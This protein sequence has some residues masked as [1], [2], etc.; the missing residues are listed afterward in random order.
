MKK[1]LQ[2]PVVL[3][4]IRILMATAFSVFAFQQVP[5]EHYSMCNVLFTCA[6]AFA[7]AI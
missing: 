3:W 1:L 2:S 5:V 7:C 4:G 6:G